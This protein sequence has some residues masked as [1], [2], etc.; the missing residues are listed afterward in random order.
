MKKII[1]Q[2]V[3]FVP[4]AVAGGI[5]GFFYWKYFGC[6]GTC[7]IT[8]NPFRTVIYFAVMGALVNQM[9]QPSKVSNKG[10]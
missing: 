8:S 4:G 2:W 9:F 5:A 1:K 7:M 10:A 3:W 6:N